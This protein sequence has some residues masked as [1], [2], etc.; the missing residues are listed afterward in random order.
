LTTDVL[1]RLVVWP[2]VWLARRGVFFQLDFFEL[3]EAKRMTTEMTAR[4]E[5]AGE[6]KNDEK[7]AATANIK[8]LRAQDAASAMREYQQER[9]QVLAR[10]ERLRALRLSRDRNASKHGEQRTAKPS[11]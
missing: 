4:M 8:Q 11:R 5:P 1:A 10:T 7:R 3:N 6:A 9:L 2:R